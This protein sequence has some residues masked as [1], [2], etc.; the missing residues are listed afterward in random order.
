MKLPLVLSLSASLGL[1]ACASIESQEAPQGA[2]VQGLSYHLPNKD[3]VVTLTVKG[4][5]PEKASIATTPAYPDLS[6]QF[7][8]HYGRN[9]LGKNTLDVTVSPSG[10][11]STANSSTQSGLTEA[12]KAFAASLGSVK[13]LWTSAVQAESPC[14][15]DGDYSFVYPKPGVYRPCGD[16][17]T[18]RIVALPESVAPHTPAVAGPEAG[19]GSAQAGIFYRQERPYKVSVTGGAVNTEALVFSP[20]QSPAHFLPIAR[21][22]FSSNNADFELSEGV[23]KRYK[24]A[25]EGEGLALL[26]LPADV[27]AAYFSAVGSL[28]DNFKNTDSKQ[29]QALSESLKLEFAKKKYDACIEALHAKDEDRLKALACN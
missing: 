9:G 19:P 18:I 7:V 27:L 16:A 28:F 24:Q 10:L 25:S 13:G 14:S 4:Q 11:L 12:F 1:L 22:F 3:F 6:R 2:P 15:T 21:S 20:S 29:A 8:L 26:K 23:P 5:K 17:V